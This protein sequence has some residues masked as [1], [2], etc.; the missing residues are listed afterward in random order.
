MSAAN[1]A[2][3]PTAPTTPPAIGAP[4]ALVI[5]PA[6]SAASAPTSNQ[7]EAVKLSSPTFAKFRVSLAGPSILY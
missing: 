2:V 6:K 3:E 4:V 7:S 1:P 5:I